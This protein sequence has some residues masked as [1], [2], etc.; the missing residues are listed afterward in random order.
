[1]ENNISEVVGLIL[2]LCSLL[3][4]IKSGIVWN[5]YKDSPKW[6]LY[7]LISC[8]MVFVGILFLIEKITILV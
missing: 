2:I 7:F 4:A 1:M 6:F 5:E 8:S 3:F